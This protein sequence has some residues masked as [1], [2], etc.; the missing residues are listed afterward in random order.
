MPTI[1][2]TA[3]I[4]IETPAGK[5]VKATNGKVKKVPKAK[6]ESNGKPAKKG[7]RGPQVRILK[8]LK[9][10]EGTPRDRNWISEKAPVDLATCVEYCGSPDPAKRKANDAKHFPSLVSLGFLKIAIPEE[11]GPTVYQI[12]KAGIA[13]LAKAE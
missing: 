2:E 3:P 7:L 13:A 10:S 6:A 12:T 4:A 1:H 8:A 11:S 5:A 9:K